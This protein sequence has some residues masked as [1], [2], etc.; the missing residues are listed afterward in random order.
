M[1][2]WPQDGPR[3]THPVSGSDIPR[4]RISWVDPT[5]SDARTQK[6]KDDS[7]NGWRRFEAETSKGGETVSETPIELVTRF[8]LSARTSS[9]VRASTQMALKLG[10]RNPSVIFSSWRW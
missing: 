7:A 1:N 6:L 10:K 3:R 5:G 2:L 4:L 9:P 8:S